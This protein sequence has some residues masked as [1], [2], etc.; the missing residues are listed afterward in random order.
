VAKAIIQLPKSVKI[1]MASISDPVARSNYKKSMLEAEA[2]LIAGKNRKFSDP[3][4]SQKKDRN[5][6]IPQS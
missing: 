3:A 6:N 5:Q 4:V 1:V 2:S